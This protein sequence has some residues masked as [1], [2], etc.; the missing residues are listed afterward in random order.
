MLKDFHICLR[1][2]NFTQNN[3]R[4]MFSNYECFKNEYVQIITY[5]IGLKRLQ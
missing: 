2:K 5:L 4:T 1:I 3:L